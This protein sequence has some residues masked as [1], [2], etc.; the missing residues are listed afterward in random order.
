MHSVDGTLVSGTPLV[1]IGIFTG[2][3]LHGRS[4]A[5]DWHAWMSRIGLVASLWDLL[6]WV[7]GG[8]NEIQ[9]YL[10]AFAAAQADGQG[11]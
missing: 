10:H 2:W 5:R 9:S 6:W 4:E 11:N 3:R 8:F 7:A 1:A